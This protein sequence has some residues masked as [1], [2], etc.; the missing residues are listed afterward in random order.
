MR[1][2]ALVWIGP[3]QPDVPPGGAVRVILMG[4]DEDR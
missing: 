2:D 4:R 3:E 1:A